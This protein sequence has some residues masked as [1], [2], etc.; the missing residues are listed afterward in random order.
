MDPYR[1]QTRPLT[2]ERIRELNQKYDTTFHDAAQ[3]EK[4]P[5][6]TSGKFMTLSLMHSRISGINN[7]SKL[8]IREVNELVGIENES[9][10]QGIVLPR[11]RQ[12]EALDASYQKSWLANPFGSSSPVTQEQIKDML[13]YYRDNYDQLFQEK[14]ALAEFIKLQAGAAERD[15]AEILDELKN[16]SRTL[17]V[18]DSAITQA[19]I[20]K[21]TTAEK[22]NLIHGEVVKLKNDQ[23]RQ[24]EE[25]LYLKNRLDK[26]N[27]DRTSSHQEMQALRAHLDKSTEQLSIINQ[28][29]TQKNHEIER[30]SS[31]HDRL[32]KSKSNIEQEKNKL[33]FEYDNLLADYNHL[34]GQLDHTERELQQFRSASE[35]LKADNDHLT[36]QLQNSQQLIY[37]QS[38]SHQKEIQHLKQS[39]NHLS[40]RHKSEIEKL[41]EENSNLQKMIHSAQ[42]DRERESKNKRAQIEKYQAEISHLSETLNQKQHGTAKL[43]EENLR[44][45]KKIVEQEKSKIDQE[46]YFEKQSKIS[47]LES[48]ITK[49]KEDIDNYKKDLENSKGSHKEEVS[50]LQS[51]LKNEKESLNNQKDMLAE[52]NR[53]LNIEKERYA[54]LK[55]SRDSNINTTN[56][57]IRKEKDAQLQFAIFKSKYQKASEELDKQ[58]EL[59]SSLAD[60]ASR[61]KEDKIKLQNQLTSKEKELHKE[62]EQLAVKMAELHHLQSVQGVIKADQAGIEFQISELSKRLRESEDNLTISRNNEAELT[63]QAQINALAMKEKDKE[64]EKLKENL[65][66]EKESEK[67]KANLSEE[68]IRNLQAQ[69]SAADNEKTRLLSDSE[70]LRAEY[71]DFRSKVDHEKIHDFVREHSIDDVD[72]ASFQ[73]SIKDMM[74][75]TSH[76]RKME[77]FKEENDALQSEVHRL[78]QLCDELAS[79]KDKVILDYAELSERVHEEEKTPPKPEDNNV[80]SIQGHEVVNI[81]NEDS[82]RQLN[83]L[84]G[85][86]TKLQTTTKKQIQE[87]MDERDEYLRK[88]NSLSDKLQKANDKISQLSKEVKDANE[89]HE[90]EACLL[91]NLQK[92]I[93]AKHTEVSKLNESLFKS[94]HMLKEAQK[95]VSHKA[96]LIDTISNFMIKQFS[97]DP[98]IRNALI[99]VL[100]SNFNPDP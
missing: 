22:L 21:K 14:R 1:Y 39:T 58:K 61:Y 27:S 25:N 90:S 77:D 87:V 99:E 85:R 15:L 11:D 47:Q 97:G 5:K 53:Q 81:N 38:S 44:L 30:Y 55:A 34:L 28:E 80:L 96:A 24:Q 69:L 36:Q 37:E 71:D 23:Q 67:T 51:K 35:N 70:K 48:T 84:K 40:H 6:D 19:D 9:K 43:E 82:E 7:V 18:L 78:M 98:A 57:Y 45:N 75:M 76:Y 50:K 63:D 2:I 60:M 72:E 93:T 92:Q 88:K 33:Q 62:K 29:L 17:M 64:I 74:S 26:L 42:E 54:V 52:T 12:V 3:F 31:I 4:I 100:G 91:D 32:Q 41:R 65:R 86:Y 79:Q 56:V 83:S 13:L 20:D 16:A 68:K 10:R 46:K 59:T 73:S 89:A 66:L 94:E 8:V 95:D 49:L